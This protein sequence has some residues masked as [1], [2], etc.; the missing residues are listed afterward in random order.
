MAAIN[1]ALCMRG[2]ESQ[3]AMNVP[4]QN[5]SV[6]RNGDWL[7]GLD[8]DVRASTIVLVAERS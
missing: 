5:P 1:D 4:V 2:L 8:I 7:E 3:S 6:W